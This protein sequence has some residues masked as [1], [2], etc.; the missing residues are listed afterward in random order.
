MGSED[1]DD[2]LFPN[3]EKDVGD[4]VVMDWARVRYFAF[5]HIYWT[6]YLGSSDFHHTDSFSMIPV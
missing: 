4:D 2:D 1:E 5:L 6:I 3:S